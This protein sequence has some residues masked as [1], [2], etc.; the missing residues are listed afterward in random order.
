ME[1]LERLHTLQGKVD[2]T[3]EAAKPQTN[4][5]ISDSLSKILDQYNKLSELQPS[6]V[7]GGNEPSQEKLSFFRRMFLLYTPHSV[8]GWVLHTLFYTLSLVF[9]TWTLFF[10]VGGSARGYD[11]ADLAIWAIVDIPIILLLLIIRYNARRHA[12]KF[13]D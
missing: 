3:D 4:L 11:T 7:V 10:L 2:A 9:W 1:L 13:E 5:V 8:P 6:R 12:A